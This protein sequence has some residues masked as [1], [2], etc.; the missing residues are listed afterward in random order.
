MKLCSNFS[1]AI[2]TIWPTHY[3]K[4]TL[5]TE[6]SYKELTPHTYMIRIRTSVQINN[7]PDYF[8]LNMYTCVAFTKAWLTWLHCRFLLLLFFDSIEIYLA[9]VK[10]TSTIAYFMSRKLHTANKL[11]I[12]MLCKW[13]AAWKWNEIMCRYHMYVLSV[14]TT[15]WLSALIQ[16][17]IQ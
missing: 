7:S 12:N 4:I 2:I 10:C 11:Y 17:N 3:H 6:A 15:Q 13:L 16:I 9:S 1:Q 8:R 14:L 5:H